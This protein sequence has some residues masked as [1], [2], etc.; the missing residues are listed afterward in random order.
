[1]MMQVYFLVAVLFL[2]VTLVSPDPGKND[3]DLLPQEFSGWRAE[4]VE[5]FSQAQLGA[6]AG[7]DAEALREYGFLAA[8]RK[9]YAHGSDRLILE[10]LRMRDASGAYGAFTYY[11]QPD[12]ATRAGRF[13]VAVSAGQGMVLRNTFCIRALGS[14][15]PA[16]LNKIAASLP[17]FKEEPLPTVRDFLPET[18]VIPSSL[19][20]VTGPVVFTRLVPQV[21]AVLMGFEMGAEVGIAQYHLPGK[22]AM[23][24]VLAHYPTPQI[25]SAKAKRLAAESN[26]PFIFRR[27][28]SL[29]SLVLGAN[30]H[31]DAGLLLDR[32]KYAMNITWN[33]AVPKH[34]EATVQDFLLM[35]LAIFKLAGILLVFATVSGVLFG[36]LRVVGTRYFPGTIFDRDAD[37]IRLHLTD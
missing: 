2:Q 1:M 28:G 34:K 24:L 8:E 23:T 5:R 37:V 26:R 21:P 29:I 3:G 14:A 17:T 30:S 6:F 22:P 9:Y 13:P 35:V 27:T 16:G 12:W 25:A 33:E 4:K 15:D 32:V 7:A 10:A 18:G 11:R 36:L 31:E 20:Y 19:R